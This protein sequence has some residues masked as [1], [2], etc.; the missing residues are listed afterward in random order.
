MT[1]RAPPD[2]QARPVV[3]VTRSVKQS[4]AALCEGIH[5]P[6]SVPRRSFARTVCG[7]V[8]RWRERRYARRGARRVLDAFHLIQ[9]QCPRLTGEDLYAATVAHLSGLDEAQARAHVRRAGNG[10]SAWTA[11]RAVRL[12]DVA[13]YLVVTDY[14]AREPRAHGTLIDMAAAVG[15]IVAGDL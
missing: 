4:W 11:Q 6:Q 8:T 15:A 13:E 10:C 7:G 1:H 9:A 3:D 14:L 12:R 2:P 5:D